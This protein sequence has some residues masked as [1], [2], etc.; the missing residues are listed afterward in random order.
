MSIGRRLALAFVLLLAVMAGFA[1]LTYSTQRTVE[2]EYRTYVERTEPTAALA[3]QAERAVLVA[4]LSIRN[5]LAFPDS[6]TY[7]QKMDEAVVTVQTSLRALENAARGTEDAA[8][9]D[10]LRPLFN[11]YWADGQ[12]FIASSL[13][14]GA[15]VAIEQRMALDR[16][17]MLAEIRRLAATL[18]ERTQEHLAIAGRALADSARV[19]MIAT[20]AALALF[21]LLGVIV[22]R[23]I[24]VP[25]ERLVEVARR[26][27]AGDPAPALAL[28]EASAARSH[29]LDEMRTL[30]YAFGEAARTIDR[31]ER[32]LD[33]DAR[34][35]RDVVSSLDTRV[36][37]EQILDDIV[38]HL[39][40]AAA[41]LYRWDKNQDVLT[42]LAGHALAPAA[43]PVLAVG[44]GLPGQAA[45]QRSRVELHGAPVDATLAVQL[46]YDRVEPG[47]AIAQPILFGDTLLG[48]LVIATL[49]EI[50][51]DDRDYL[52]SAA[53]L[54]AIGLR[55]SFAHER[56]LE[57]LGH[58]RE[59]NAEIQRAHEELQAQNEEIQAQN[60]EIQA[61]HEE[62]QAQH[63]EMQA[64][65]EQLAELT[66]SL[67]QHAEE[68]TAADQRKNDFLAV[69]A[70]ELRNPMAPIITSLA[71]LR[72]TC[73][74]DEQS[75]AAMRAIERQSAHLTR[76][77][78]D[79]LDIT[80]ISRGKVELQRQPTDL[81]ALIE[82]CAH[83]YREAIE[84]KGIALELRLPA[85]PLVADIDPDRIVQAVGNLLHNAM[86]FTPR[87]GH[88]AVAVRRLN[89]D[90]MVS[91]TDDGSGMTPE[92]LG[93]LFQ[94][95]SQG[96]SELDRQHGGLGLGLALVKGLIEQHGGRVEAYSD[97]PGRGSRF[98]LF[99]PVLDGVAASGDPSRQDAGTSR[100]GG[101]RHR[102]LI[103][104]DNVDAADVLRMA[105]DWEGHE[106]RVAH[107]GL[108]VLALADE[109]APDIIL[110]DI[111]L[112]GIDGY[113]VAR[114][115][116]SQ[117]RHA[118]VLLVAVT[119]YASDSDR[120]RTRE[121]GFDVHL[122]KP[123]DFERLTQALQRAEP[124]DHS[125]A[126]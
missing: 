92:L 118:H 76:L 23:S 17:R 115:L 45:R 37:A 40:A 91:V 51:D 29:D 18:E 67:R 34:L 120:R 112:P 111:G 2:R 70:H 114:R 109:F 83:D 78:E 21:A 74:Q 50:D 27:Q 98:V 97:G 108:D 110:C 86:K 117:A 16:E 28:T 124:G 3:R 123:V 75:G 125:S 102:I 9:A 103:A 53:T 121:A 61:Q 62:L 116:R 12:A 39:G 99:L 6:D 10:S 107:D 79:L 101:I 22:A 95:F 113:E 100:G 126:F 44:E 105:L 32:R 66:D 14:G 96:P 5:Y 119:G 85:P 77:I 88:I 65:N 47:H 106:V 73:P 20:I 69:L 48:V 84:A 60:E 64:Q 26:W 1:L 7:R 8:L 42:A 122:A 63:E 80:R 72:R 24:R 71:I 19:G 35:C 11:I 56:I 81:V 52:E 4:A 41:V 57:L 13:A 36:L 93:Q 59:R 30:A 90:A 58:M 43:Q 89:G 68:A 94:P 54:T 38:E 33:A 15:D 25:V 49:R 82:S 46:G 104:D 31:R 87:G 55:N